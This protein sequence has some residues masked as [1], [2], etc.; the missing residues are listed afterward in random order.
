MRIKRSLLFLF[1]IITAFVLIGCKVEKP[2]DNNDDVVNNNQDNNQDNNQEDDNNEDEKLPDVDYEAELISYFDLNIPSEVNDDVILD[3]ELLL[4]DDSEA[5]IVW[6]S[7][8]GR[9]LSKKGVYKQNLF[10][11]TIT[12]TATVTV[13]KYIEEIDDFNIFEYVIEKNVITKGSEDLDEYKA[14]I[15]SYIPDYVYKDFEIVSRDL[16]YKSKNLF[17]NISY[18]S[19]MPEVLTEEGKYVNTNVEDQ[20]VDFNYLVEI[21]GI[22]ITGTK[23]VTVEGK[24][25]DYY[26]ECASTWLDNYF[27]NSRIYDQLILPGTDDLDRVTITW[28]S[29]DLTVVSNQGKLLAYEPNRNVTMYATIK[30]NDSVATWE[31]TFTTYSNEEILDFIVN[32]IHRDVIQ[33]YNMRVYCYTAENYGFLPFYNQDAAL[34]DLVVSTTANNSKVNYLTEGHNSNV[35]KSNIVTGLIPWNNPGRT[36]IMKESTDFITIH[37]TGD[38]IH[39]ATWWNNLETTLDDRQTSW[40][41]TVGDTVIYQHVP[42]D[43]VAWH[44]GDGSRTFA[45]YDTGV[46]YQGPDPKITLGDDHYL[47]INGESSKIKVPIIS[48]SAVSEYNGQYANAITPAGLYTCLGANGNYYMAKV[49]ASNYSQYSRL[50]YVSTCGGNRNSIGI[51]TCINKGVD[52]NQVMRNTANLVG[53]LLVYYDLDPSRVL[54]HRN[55]SGKLCPQVMIEND[56]GDNFDN[57]VENEYIIKKYLPE[58]SITYKSNNPDIMNNDGKVLKAV[59]SDTEVSYTVTASFNGVTKTFNMSTVIKPIK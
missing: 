44:A 55:F 58:L 5:S 52:Y 3:T 4:S 26:L 40:H 33:Q 18:T 2:D 50:F 47:H 17:G 53:N 19:S 23:K 57:M 51:E 7:S 34:S 48:G 8:N 25:D 14:I 9:T 22:E 36:Q 43:E 29:G 38:G 59:N 10:D 24:K 45:L 41:F 42:L 39:D 56:L 27:E 1:F 54:Q 46:K 32:R 31:K 37:D 21:N 12:L 6:E 15:E 13:V 20:I 16:T 11:E 35:G 28:K 49:Y 30:V